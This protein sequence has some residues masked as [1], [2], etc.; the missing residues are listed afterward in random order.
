MTMNRVS[1][2]VC[3]VSILLPAI[4]CA[5]EFRAGRPE[6][7][8]GRG[9]ALTTSSLRQERPRVEP[10]A[11]AVKLSRIDPKPGIRRF[12]EATLPN[13]SNSAALPG[14][15][16]M[17]NDKISVVI[18]AP[19]HPIGNAVSGG[20][21]IDAFTNEH[22]YDQLAQ[23]H[24]YLN[25][26]YP[27]QANYKE[28]RIVT[29]SKSTDTMMLEVSGV[30][31]DDPSV[32]IMTTYTLQA[33]SMAVEI[34]TAFT[35]TSHPL[36]NFPVGDVTSWGQARPFV[37]GEGFGVAAGRVDCDWIGGAGKGVAYG[38]YAD[39]EARVWGPVG[40][41]WAD[42]SGT[43]MSVSLGKVG[44]YRR[45]FVVARDLAEVLEVVCA[46]KGV[47]TSNVAGVVME[48]ITGRKFLDGRPGPNNVPVV[49]RRA[50]KTV[51]QAFTDPSGE[52]RM[53][54][55]DG[56]YTIVTEDPFRPKGLGPWK[57]TLPQD[58]SRRILLSAQAP[59]VADIVV[60]DAENGQ[61]LPCKA[62]FIG[63]NG[64]SDPLLG[65]L[66]ERIGRNVVNLP[67]GAERIA[68]PAGSYDIVISRGLDYH[69][70]THSVTLA[71][72]QESRLE[73]R[74]E[75]AVTR[76]GLVSGDFHQHMRNSFDS[77]IP[78]EDRV[79]SN[80][81]EGLDFFVS[82]D[83][84]FITDLSPVVRRLGLDQW[85]TSIIGDEMT[86]RRHFFGHVNAFPLTVDTSK[87]RNGAI[88]FEGTI[89]ARVFKDAREFAGEQVVQVNHPRSGDLGYF[90][91]VAMSR[92]DGSTTHLNWSD[93]FTAV[94]IFNGKHL[95]DAE[96]SLHD[97]FNLL[98]IGYVFTATGNSDS[99][100]IHDQEP[101]YPRSYV[102]L[103]VS[104]AP[105]IRQDDLV[106]AVNEKHSVFVT[107]G[108]ILTL[109]GDGGTDI[110]SS[111]TRTSGPV[112]FKVR[113]EGA[114]FVQPSVV[115]FIGNGKVLKEA[116]FDETSA[117]LKWEGSFTDE[118]ASDTWYVIVC[119][120]T[121]SLEPV[122]KPLSADTPARPFA[123][124]NPIWVDRDGDGVFR[125]P[126][127]SLMS[128]MQEDRSSAAL[129]ALDRL[130]SESQRRT[131][132]VPGAK[133]STAG[134]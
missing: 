29:D 131:P 15:Y 63:T 55:P 56:E 134:E 119:R 9:A 114:N 73:T 30:D 58:E 59:A 128:M 34:A 106:K 37:S 82:T 46:A 83:H 103:G 53:S 10:G 64:T 1:L 60:T 54:L 117:S 98:N 77:A 115:Q 66:Y 5:A 122:V 112:H 130:T 6:M 22:P 67:K 71:P 102:A 17:Q 111:C 3:A 23:V 33:G 79:I 89:A 42:V 99:H 25:D 127:A 51:A 124:T 108:P 48:Q 49:A 44:V 126:N 116:S 43:T 52:F 45:H 105:A 47:K 38:L 129:A 68:V 109:L 13:G 92:K 21:I 27:R 125:G 32:K 20:A 121:R 95:E 85:T 87:P 113:V 101:G 18:N 36:N 90:N 91:R 7:P 120:G 104:G 41:D 75:R 4:A 11:L 8:F 19:N 31:T 78:P 118:P 100:R 76:R 40:T 74:L 57:G 12:P 84:N 50:G 69:I 88:P 35:C 72:N 107:N 93:Q 61:S 133:R 110:G 132:R 39:G 62:T 2:L 81:C 28:A 96:D 24:L 123:F 65:P 70:T 94:E 80:A 86:P 97:W 16:L 26:R 14:D